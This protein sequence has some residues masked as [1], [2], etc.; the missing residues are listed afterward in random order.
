MDEEIWKTIPISLKFEASTHGRIRNKQTGR[1]HKSSKTPLGYL[2]VSI[3][4]THGEEITNLVHRLVAITFLP[5]P[6]NKPTVNHLR[7]GRSNNNVSNLE[8]ATRQRQ[9][10]HSRK[11]KLTSDEIGFEEAWGARH[12]WKCDKQTGEKLEMFETVRDAANSVQAARCMAKINTVAEGHE[13]ST[14]IPDHRQCITST[15]GFKWE[16]DELR[17]LTKEEWRDID[18]IDV[19][20]AKGYQIST[21]GRL[22]TPTGEVKSPSGPSYSKH[23]L[24][25]EDFLAH[26]LVALTFIPRV[27]GKTKVNHLDGNKCNP[28]I[29]N[30]AWVTQSE[31]LQHAHA[32]GL[33]TPRTTK[34]LQYDPDGR[35]V[36]Q[37]E[38]V[39]EARLKFGPISINRSI[40][41]GTKA[42]G[43]HWKH[44]S[45]DNL[46]WNNRLAKREPP[47]TKKV[48]QF[49]M[50]GSFIRSFESTQYAQIAVPGLHKKAPLR[51]GSSAGYLWKY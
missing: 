18:S 23:Y 6:E 9:A 33:K 41:T 2:A 17:V 43:Y 44:A 10:D 13:I 24:C 25:N 46:A 22:C 7:H 48:N 50:A 38:S 11:R 29:D 19:K 5:N 32:T 3:K 21:L 49:D 39:K 12:I 28:N 36:R 8:W 51:R 27:E 14:S 45:T 20:G 30:L 16:F 42:G 35:F 47:K 26:R 37:F 15:A 40:N 1:V 31:N 4:G 34:V